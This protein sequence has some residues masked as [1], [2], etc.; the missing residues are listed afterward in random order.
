MAHRWRA[1]G[2]AVGNGVG[3][4]LR[5]AGRGRHADLA[6]CRLR[7]HFASQHR[8]PA[9]PLEGRRRHR[10]D[11]RGELRDGGV[12]RLSRQP[13]RLRLCP[14]R[15]D[16]AATGGPRLPSRL[17]GVGRLAS[18]R[19]DRLP[20]PA[21]HLHPWRG[22]CGELGDAPARRLHS[23]ADRGARAD[24]GAADAGRRDFAPGNARPSICSTPMSAAAPGS[25]SLR[26]ASVAATSRP[27]ARRSGFQTCAASPRVPT[28]CRRQ[29]SS[30]SSIAISIVRYPR[31][32][33]RAARC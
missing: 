20:D 28:G 19:R 13:D 22:A 17:P 23:S 11:R 16:P 8:R 5:E 4:A 14:W 9:L 29:S 26:A 24:R 6:G 18:G 7:T 31:S 27:S 15:A 12:R 30:L 21:A 1:L 33:A 2:G 3:A 32:I 10:G 25:A